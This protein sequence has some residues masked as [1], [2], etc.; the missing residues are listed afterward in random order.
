M[1]QTCK[2][3]KFNNDWKCDAYDFYLE[4]K[5]VIVECKSG[6]LWEPRTL[7]YNGTLEPKR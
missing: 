4:N 1:K 5:D 6:E 3:C 2:N 7:I